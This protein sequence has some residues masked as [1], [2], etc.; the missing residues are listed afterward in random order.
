LADMW[1]HFR[2]YPR[3]HYANKCQL[4]SLKLVLRECSC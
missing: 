4:L 3:W 1:E 2:F